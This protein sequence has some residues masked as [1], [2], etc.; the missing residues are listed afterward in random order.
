MIFLGVFRFFLFLIFLNNDL[1]PHGNH[2]NLCSCLESFHNVHDSDH[3]IFKMVQKM[4]IKKISVV[5]LYFFCL[6]SSQLFRLKYNLHWGK[7]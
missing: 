2:G 5:F 3:S 6:G 4:K 7:D 1:F